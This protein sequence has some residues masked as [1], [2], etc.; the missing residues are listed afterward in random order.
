MKKAKRK[1][2]ATAQNVVDIIGDKL[3]EEKDNKED[4]IDLSKIAKNLADRR[5]RVLKAED[6]ENN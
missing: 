3:K 5:E 1:A 6:E 2:V 4:K